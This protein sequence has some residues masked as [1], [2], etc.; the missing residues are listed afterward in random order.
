MYQN[1][2]FLKSK[3]ANFISWI[4]PLLHTRI[5]AANECIYYEGDELTDI[6]FLKS[7]EANYVLPRYGNTP[8]VKIVE[9]TCFGLIDIIAALLDKEKQIK[10]Y[11]ILNAMS[12]YEENGQE[13]VDDDELFNTEL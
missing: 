12:N 11:G 7:G 3:E 2:D 4:C 10:A 9:H 1:V 6:Y 13:A 8:F 5:A